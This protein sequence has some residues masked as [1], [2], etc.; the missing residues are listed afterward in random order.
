MFKTLISF[1]ILL[2]IVVSV[3][4]AVNPD[5]RAQLVT[6]GEQ[7]SKLV[8]QIIN[9]IKERATAASPAGIALLLGDRSA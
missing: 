8:V 3:A 5:V 1:L 2:A 6:I 9:Q 7:V 4:A